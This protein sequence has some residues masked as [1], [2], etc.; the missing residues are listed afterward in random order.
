VACIYNA[1]VLKIRN[2]ILIFGKHFR[3]VI[4]LFFS[5][6]GNGNPRNLENDFFLAGKERQ[7]EAP[8]TGKKKHF[9]KERLLHYT[10]ISIGVQ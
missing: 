4:R 9:L 1:K 10:F 7:A 5:H 3:I 8:F 2:T 6:D